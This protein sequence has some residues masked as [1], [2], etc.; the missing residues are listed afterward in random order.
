MLGIFSILMAILYMLC[1]LMWLVVKCVIWIIA[2]IIKG[3][4]WLF[5]VIKEALQKA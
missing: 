5:W 4:I 2:W 3:I 1:S